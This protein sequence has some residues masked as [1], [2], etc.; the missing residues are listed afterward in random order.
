MTTT[1]YDKIKS[2]GDSGLNELTK[3]GII[4]AETKRRLFIYEYYLSEL[5]ND[6]GKM[7]A[8]TNTA[9]F[10]CTSEA[11]VRKIVEKFAKTID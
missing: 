9:E 4:K 10:C 2:I 6:I 7:Q 1:V 8:Y 5:N 3:I 11:N